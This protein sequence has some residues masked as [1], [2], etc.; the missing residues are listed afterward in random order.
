[1]RLLAELADRE[2]DR[3]RALRLFEAAAAKSRHQSLA[4][5]RLLLDS[6]ARG[7]AAKAFSYADVLMRAR[8]AAIPAAAPVLTALAEKNKESTALKA[9]LA[10]NPPWRA[11][12]FSTML[13]S[14]T[15][16]RTPLELYLS[17]KGT[18]NPPKPQ[19][20]K[21]YLDFLISQQF[22]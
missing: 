14:I 19:E 4:Y 22:P 9:L 10:E 3:E 21:G 5:Y 2:G 6:V 11:N 15:D 1:M 16:A 20:L 12:F 13:G 7:D 8:P 17:L 18:A